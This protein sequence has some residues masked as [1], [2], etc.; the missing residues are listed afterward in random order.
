MIVRVRGVEVVCETMEELDQIIE[1]Y[2]DAGASPIGT[3]LGPSQPAAS[4]LNGAARKAAALDNGLLQAFVNSPAGVQS[5]IVEGLLGIRGKAIPFALR[6]WAK[7]VHIAPET[8]AR[9]NP[10]GK[11]GWKLNESGIAAARALMMT[12]N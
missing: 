4:S 2:G 1:R 8:I 9:A 5:K 11:R 3:L 12:T 7:R 6:A 10:G